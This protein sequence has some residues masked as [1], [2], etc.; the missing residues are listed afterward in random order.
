M[1]DR[2]LSSL[3][4]RPEA[5]P[6]L[7]SEATARPVAGRADDAGLVKHIEEVSRNCRPLLWAM[8]SLCAFVVIT[9]SGMGDA[10]LLLTGVPVELPFIEAKLPT[11]GFLFVAPLA[12]VGV[13]AYFHVQLYYLWESIGLWA[14]QDESARE[15]TD[16]YPWLISSYLASL[17]RKTAAPGARWAF[18]V[19]SVRSVLA[20]FLGWISVPF[21]LLVLWS[22]TLVKHDVGLSCFYIGLFFVVGLVACSAHFTPRRRHFGGRPRMLGFVSV[23]VVTSGAIVLSEQVLAAPVECEGGTGLISFL[24]NPGKIEARGLSLRG[25]TLNL[26]LCGA[27]LSQ[28]DLRGADLRGCQL[29]GADLSGA[30]LTG[31]TLGRC[32]PM[33]PDETEWPESDGAPATLD[34]V[35]LRKAQLTGAELCRVSLNQ[36][37]LEGADLIRAKLQKATLVGTNLTNANLSGAGLEFAILDSANM[38]EVNLHRANLNE[39]RLHGAILL[40]ADLTRATFVHAQLPD[41][42][43]SEAK[44]GQAKFE[45]SI[46]TGAHFSKATFDQTKLNGADLTNVF[47]LTPGQLSLACAESEQYLDVAL[48][49]VDEKGVA[50]LDRKNYPLTYCI[51]AQG[52]SLGNAVVAESADRT[53]T[54]ALGAEVWNQAAIAQITNLSALAPAPEARAPEDKAEVGG[55]APGYPR[56]ASSYAGDSSPVNA[57]RS[58]ASV[59]IIYLSS[60]SAQDDARR[61]QDAND[62]R[63]LLPGPKVKIASSSFSEFRSAFERGAVQIVYPKGEEHLLRGIADV[64]RRKFSAV[65]LSYSQSMGSG[66]VQIWLF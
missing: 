5:R 53:D 27:D 60:G 28:A 47:D 58:A 2:E 32:K 1:I 61:E 11:E 9:V 13:Y 35:N 37:D 62:L 17:A 22:R 55:D 63:R 34:R 44:L 59:G 23:V 38:T 3:D 43:L 6:L 54:Q 8:L 20:L 36:A 66:M 65:K 24:R 33:S 7:G 64:V 21:S 56:G 10:S 42:D 25:E 12:L 40:R 52:M 29:V 30:N 19:P 49:R 51:E 15:A 26:P 4:D 14:Q 18:L 41:A 57:A 46:L 48:L 45:W 31:A 50:M 16:I 39:A